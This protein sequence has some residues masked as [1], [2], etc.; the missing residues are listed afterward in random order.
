[1]RR[2]VAFGCELLGC[3]FCLRLFG[4]LF[5]L[6]FGNNLDLDVRG[7]FAVQADAY[8]DVAH[9]LQ[10]VAELDLAAIDVEALGFKFGCSRSPKATLSNTDKLS[11]RAAP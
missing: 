10:R 7:D 5:F 11:K 9:G 2:V 1:M 3:G 8:D 4:G 6:S